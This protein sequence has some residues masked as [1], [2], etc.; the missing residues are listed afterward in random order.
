MGKIKI[1][2]IMCS[3][4]TKEEYLYC[5]IDSILNQTFKDF[6][7]ILIDDGSS[8]FPD[9]SSF[10]DDRLV[11]VHNKENKGIPYSRNL[12]LKLAK[13][14]YIAIM[15]SDDIAE[16]NRLE[17]EFN[18][19][20]NNPNVVVCGS[21]FKQ[22]GEKNNTCRRI[23]DDTNIYKAFLLFGNSPTLL[24]PSSMHRKS[25][26]DEYKFSYSPEF[27]VG[28]DYMMWVQ[29]SEIGDIRNINKV[30]MNYRVHK[31]QITQNN[32][33]RPCTWEIIK[34]QLNKINYIFTEIDKTMFL[35]PL[36]SKRYSLKDYYM[37]LQKIQECNDKTF[38]FDPVSL[39]KVCEYK[40][41]QK[42]LN[43][44][45]IFYILKG[46]KNLKQERST[47]FKN[48]LRHFGLFRNIDY[49]FRKYYGN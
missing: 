7:L 8:V 45:N 15:D 31:G 43:S 19:M 22:F 4:N 18:Y 49:E 35:E 3:Y 47:I 5:A 6:E 1:S 34:Y 20:E 21:W 29:M 27:K 40:W 10:N 12:G 46:A 41:H 33:K 38:Y 36:N 23:I 48:Y 30:L 24:D 42:I 9:L 39:K 25:S 26:L 14:K 2:V 44:K 28:L 37:M 17:E 11:I 13:G 16:P 32:K